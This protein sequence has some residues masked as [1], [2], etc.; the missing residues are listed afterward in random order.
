MSTVFRNCFRLVIWKMREKAH[1]EWVDT[2][3]SQRFFLG[4]TES[5]PFLF[6]F[7]ID[8][9]FVRLKYYWLLWLKTTWGLIVNI[10]WHVSTNF[11]DNFRV[12]RLP[13]VTAFEP[14]QETW[15]KRRFLDIK[16]DFIEQNKHLLSKWESCECN[17]M[18][19]IKGKWLMLLIFW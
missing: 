2:S 10:I 11:I 8:K 16:R 12:F 9:A 19:I 7:Y 13:F 6:S 3:V 4:A 15:T 5:A 17:H 18:K 1:S 14:E